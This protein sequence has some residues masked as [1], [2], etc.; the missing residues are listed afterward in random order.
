METVY[1]QVCGKVIPEQDVTID[2]P[3]LVEYEKAKGLAIEIWCLECFRCFQEVYE[4]WK[5]QRSLSEAERKSSGSNVTS[6]KRGS[7]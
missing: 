4:E 3:T 1:C 2:F 6:T 7:A 5:K